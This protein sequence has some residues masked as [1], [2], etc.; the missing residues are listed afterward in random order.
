M[1]FKWLFL[2]LSVFMTFNSASAQTWLCVGD[3]GVSI[4]KVSG[5]W[6]ITEVG[7]GKWTVKRNEHGEYTLTNF[8]IE[9]LKKKN[10]LDLSKAQLI[11]YCYQ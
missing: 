10:T 7:L 8:S 5:S 4:D 6:K 3:K 1:C 2:S 11:Y 9:K